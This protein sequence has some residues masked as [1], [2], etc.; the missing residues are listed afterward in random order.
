MMDYDKLKQIRN[1]GIAVTV[2]NLILLAAQI[3]LRLLR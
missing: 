3:L 2:I 1:V